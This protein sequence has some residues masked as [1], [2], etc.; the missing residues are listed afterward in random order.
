MTTTAP[1]LDTTDLDA[2]PAA[3]RAAY[4]MRKS[5]G[6]GTMRIYLVTTYTDGSQWHRTGDVGKTTGDRP[7]FLLM[8]RFSDIGSS[9]LLTASTWTNTVV[10]GVQHN[11]GGYYTPGNRPASIPGV[12]YREEPRTSGGVDHRVMPGR[13]RY[14]PAPCVECGQPVNG[15]GVCEYAELDELA[16]IPHGVQK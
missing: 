4:A 9:D 11:G 12:E 14:I 16:G 10:A 2:A 7:A 13:N 5:N 15:A 6:S 8:G 3:V 1:T